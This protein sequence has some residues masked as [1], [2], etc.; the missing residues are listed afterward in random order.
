MVDLHLNARVEEMTCRIWIECASCRFRVYLETVAGKFPTG[1]A[2][3]EDGAALC[4]VHY[5][6][7]SSEKRS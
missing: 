1:W 5:G 4:P 2:L 6:T 3:K 7:F